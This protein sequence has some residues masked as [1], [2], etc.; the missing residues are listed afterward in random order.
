VVLFEE[1]F[2]NDRDESYAVMCIDVPVHGAV[3]STD[4]L[5]QPITSYPEAEAFLWRNARMCASALIG[6]L[7]YLVFDRQ[8]LI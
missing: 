2:Y 5:T 3:V 8:P 7:C 1:T 6:R 4:R